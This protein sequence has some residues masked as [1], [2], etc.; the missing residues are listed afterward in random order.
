[1][2]LHTGLPIFPGEDEYEQLAMFM[3]TLGLPPEHLL[4][5]GTRSKK[6]FKNYKPKVVSN[7]HGLIR[8][9]NSKTL[10]D[11]L[12]RT[13]SEPFVDLVRKCLV[14]DPE[15]RITPAEALLHPWII[16]GIPEE[17]R[18]HHIQSIEKNSDA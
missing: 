17:I 3:E 11:L 8:K 5:Q 12:S 9:P 16:Q 4:D 7:R 2:E 6:F 18:K 13:A 10:D 15:V 14:W 1:V